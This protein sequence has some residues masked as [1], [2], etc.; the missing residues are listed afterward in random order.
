HHQ[1]S[2]GSGGEDSD[3]LSGLHHECLASLEPLERRNDAIVRSPV[4]GC[5]RDRHVDDQF[6]RV[7]RVLQIVLEQS[8]DG[9]LTPP[10]AA[11]PPTSH[12]DDSWLRHAHTTSVSPRKESTMSGSPR[13]WSPL[14]SYTFRPEES[15]TA[16]SATASALWVF[17]STRSTAQ[18]AS[19]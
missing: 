3:R 14:A 19:L 8:Q 9:L 17:C 1:R 7:L 4:S 12:G 11:E 18:P 16:R 13:A 10:L 5:L 15:T 2:V 6:G